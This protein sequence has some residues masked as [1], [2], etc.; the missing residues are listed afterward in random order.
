MDFVWP[1]TLVAA[2]T[3]GPLALLTV[4]IM[5]LRERSRL[6]RAR[7]VWWR[8]IG[9]LALLPLLGISFLVLWFAIANFPFTSGVI[10][11]ASSP[12]GE[13]ACVVQTFKGAEPYQV[14][15]YVRS[16]GQPWMWHYLAHQ[17]NRW[18][19]CHIE[20]A[21]PQ[22]RVYTDSSLRKSFSIAEATSRPDSSHEELPT[23]FTPEQ[24][25]AQHNAHYRN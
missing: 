13:E 16:P 7:V 19:G 15:L 14:S 23:S 18:S 21:G 22:L 5:R 2:I 11:H 6:S 9:F 12:A 10:A 25:L 24:I 20:F 17:D 3:V 8:S 4:A 1:I